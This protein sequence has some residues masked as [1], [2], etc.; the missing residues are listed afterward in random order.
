MR[1]LAILLQKKIS[2]PRFAQAV[3]FGKIKEVV[4]TFLAQKQLRMS[5]REFDEKTQTLTIK[6]SHPSIAREILGYHQEFNDVLKKEGLPPIKH[7]RH[8]ATS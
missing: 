2:H 3:T 7:I 1:K 8:Q 6:T 5:V 4:E